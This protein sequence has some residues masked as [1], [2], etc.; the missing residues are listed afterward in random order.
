M[1]TTVIPMTQP[2]RNAGPFT[3]ALTENSIRMQAMIGI[4]LMAMPT[5]SGNRSPSALSNIQ[6]FRGRFVVARSRA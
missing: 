3:R 1:V 4:G 5:A 6:S 2:R